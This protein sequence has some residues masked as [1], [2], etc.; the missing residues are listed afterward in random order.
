VSLALPPVKSAA[1]TS[2]KQVT[3]TSFGHVIVGG[4]VSTTVMV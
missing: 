2:A 1:G 3:V 4:V